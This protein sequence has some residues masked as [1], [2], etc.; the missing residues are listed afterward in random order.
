MIFYSAIFSLSFYII[1]LPAINNNYLPQIRSN[2][3]QKHFPT[4]SRNKN[5][6]KTGG[7]TIV[8]L[9]VLISDVQKIINV[10]CCAQQRC[11]RFYSKIKRDCLFKHEKIFAFDFET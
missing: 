11:T 6:I 5:T 9:F 4:N 3:V 8:F 10:E 7:A 1:S 2:H